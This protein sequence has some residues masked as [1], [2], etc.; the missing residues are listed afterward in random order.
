MHL[1]KSAVLAVCLVAASW[2]VLANDWP[3]WRGPDRTDVSKETGLLKQ[4]PDKGPR[5]LWTYAE[6]GAGYSCPAIVGN[7]LA[8]NTN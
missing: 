6:A 4:W 3:Q 8:S 1:R 2:P 7:C 5:L